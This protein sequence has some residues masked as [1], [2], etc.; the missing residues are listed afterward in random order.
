M[1]E[2]LQFKRYENRLVRNVCR[3][4][5]KAAGRLAEIT[6]R[7]FCFLGKPGSVMVVPQT[8]K[9]IISFRVTPLILLFTVLG[10]M[11]TF[12]LFFRLGAALA[13]GREIIHKENGNSFAVEAALYEFRTES[14]ELS[15]R[16][17]YIEHI[18]AGMMEREEKK[19]DADPEKNIFFHV[20][21]VLPKNDWS[22]P[23]CYEDELETTL[24]SL[25]SSTERL[26]RLKDFMELYRALRAEIPCIRPVPD[27]IGYISMTFGLNRHPYTRRNYLHRGLDISGKEGTPILA[28][29]GGQVIIAEYDN[30]GGFGNQIFIEHKQYYTR[31]AHL[32]S[33]RVKAGQTVHQGEV[34]GFMGNTGLSTGPHL[35]YEIYFGGVLVDPISFI[36]RRIHDDGFLPPE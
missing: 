36:N 13:G 1:A 25:T 16:A 15:V 3:L 33:F 18:L 14:T 11:G 35:H 10:V 19:A 31:Y 24:G 7:F 12:Y 5:K 17:A 29:A 20:P 30:A 32:Q 22:F 9:K 21:A 26:N 27:G 4:C 6:N 28:A 8:E 2:I 23:E 34:I